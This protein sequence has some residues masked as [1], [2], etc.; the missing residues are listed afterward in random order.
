MP[1]QAPSAAASSAMAVATRAPILRIPATGAGAFGAIIRRLGLAD[2]SP[3]QIRFLTYGRAVDTSR[4]RHDFG[5]IPQHTTPE[6]FDAF[7]RAHRLNRVL[8]PER[9]EAVEEQLVSLLTGRGTSD[10]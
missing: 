5:F 10:D 8:P 1:E 3:E 2:F 6:T 7:V 9:V 4:M